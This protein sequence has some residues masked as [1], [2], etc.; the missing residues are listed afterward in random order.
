MILL[1]DPLQ[2]AQ[3][4]LAT[5]PGGAGASTLEHV[6]ADAATIPDDRGVFLDTTWR[7]HRTLCSF[8]SIQI[9]DGRL[10]SHENCER[11]SVGGEAGLRWVRAEH[12]GC[13]TSSVVEA[14]LVASTIRSLLG[15]TWVD[16]DG[17][18]HTMHAGHVMVVAPYNDHV[19]I[20]R[21]V[22]DADPATS[23]ARVGT[24]DKF[25]GQEA[26]VVIFTMATSNDA[27]MPRTA[28]FLYSRNRLNVA[29]S[30]A[31]ALAYVICTE[32]LLDTRAASVEEMRLIGTLCAFVESADTGS[33]D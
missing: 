13:D 2:L 3:V 18:E 33:L 5:H 32:D 14:E 8:L 26:P 29:I 20:V 31:R 1:G 17:N 10:H 21:A 6:L 15:K 22:L 25:Q 30:R 12:D 28:D 9:Y 11:Q 7:M 24:V 19:D 23:A 27:D 4:S 16:F